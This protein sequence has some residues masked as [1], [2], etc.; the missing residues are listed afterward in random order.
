MQAGKG[1]AWLSAS[2]GSVSGCYYTGCH[3][4]PALA[5][6]LPYPAAAAREFNILPH[7]R[8]GTRRQ[9]TRPKLDIYGSRPHRLRPQP[10]RGLCFGAYQLASATMFSVCTMQQSFVRLAPSDWRRSD[11]KLSSSHLESSS[12]VVARCS[13]S[14]EQDTL[15]LL[16]LHC[17]V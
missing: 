16:L 3:G 14:N 10:S 15:L 12:A 7:H 6:M 17:I 5:V 11:S 13:R 8:L 2:G 1:M 4:P 9:P